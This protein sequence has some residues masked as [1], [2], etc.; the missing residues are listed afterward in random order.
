MGGTLIINI[1]PTRIRLK[2][3]TNVATICIANFN[4]VSVKLQGLIKPE[5]FEQQRNGKVGLGLRISKFI[6][7]K[8]N[9]V[10]TS[11]PYMHSRLQY[12]YLYLQKTVLGLGVC[13]NSTHVQTRKCSDSATSSTRKTIAGR[14]PARRACSEPL[15]GEANGRILTNERTNKRTNNHDSSLYLLMAE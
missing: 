7:Q 15:S 3:W 11:L 2:W 1:R 12:S 10:K 9:S 14:V 4:S 6:T 8:Y 13:F 5:T